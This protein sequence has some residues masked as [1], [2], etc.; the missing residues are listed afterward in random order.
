MDQ[1]LINATAVRRMCGGVSDMT[2]WRWLNDP[3]IAFPKPIYIGKRRYFRQ[4]DISAWI[5]TRPATDAA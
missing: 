5:E 3:T 4:A 1:Q 2:L